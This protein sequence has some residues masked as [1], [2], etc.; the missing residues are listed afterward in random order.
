MRHSLCVWH[1]TK[2]EAGLTEMTS[3]KI[4]IREATEKG[5]GSG[6]G[7]NGEEYAKSSCTCT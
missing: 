1:N 6:I 3:L 4:N 2:E 5:K 7:I